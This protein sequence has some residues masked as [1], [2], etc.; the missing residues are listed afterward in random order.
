M[1]G[2]VLAGGKGTRMQSSEEKLLL[3][4]QKPLI[5][6]VAKAMKDSQ[7]FSKI[8]FLTSKNSPKTKELL[9]KN[10]FKIID[11]PGIGYVEDLNLV[12][13][14]LDDSV[15]VTSGDLPLL[16]ME[17]I[18]KIVELYDP[19]KPW[20]SI[21]ITKNF[22]NSNQLSSS[23]EITF[24]NQLCSYTGISMINSKSIS[25]L[26]KVTENFIIVNDKRIGF[27]VNTKQD[28]ELLSTT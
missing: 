24:E 21:L 8:L 26:D 13:K 27:N 19:T 9:L 3:K 25:N 10:N 14:S 1:I 23:F 16:D 22:L 5:L 17:I 6:H 4:Y 28:Y 18:K 11:T 15:F 20:T 2:I 12:L 7:C